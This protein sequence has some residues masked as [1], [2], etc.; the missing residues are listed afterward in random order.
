[1]KKHYSNDD[2][3]NNNF[4]NPTTSN[5]DGSDFASDE[6]YDDEEE[7]VSRG[8]Q[9]GSAIKNSRVGR[10]VGNKVDKAK[11]NIKDLPQNAK[12]TATKAKDK[13]SRN[14]KGTGKAIKLQ[15]KSDFEANH[16]VIAQ[17]GRN[18]ADTH[19][20]MNGLRNANKQAKQTNEKAKAEA[21]KKVSESN[22]NLKKG[23][24][25]YKKE[26]K[27]TI[28]GI[29][30]SD[31]YK[32]QKS[33]NNSRR[34]NNI[35][36]VGKSLANGAGAYGNMAK[37][38]A[39]STEAYRKIQSAYAKMQGFITFV[40]VNIVP[41]LIITAIIIVLWNGTIFGISVYQAMGDTPHYYCKL[42]PPGWEKSN[43]WYQLYCTNGRSNFAL[44]ELNGHYIIQDGGGPC[45]CS[46]M[47]NLLLRYF[48]ANGVNF[49]DYLWDENGQYNPNYLLETDFGNVTL[50]HFLNANTSNT[51]GSNWS[52]GY[53]A[54]GSRDFASAHNKGVY[55]MA[56]WGYLR[57]DQ[58]ANSFGEMFDAED[59]DW[60]WDLSMEDRAPGTSWGMNLNSDGHWCRCLSSTGETVTATL[61]C[62]TPANDGFPLRNPD[63]FANFLNEHPSGVVVYQ[64][65]H[66]ILVTRCEQV[67]P[68]IYEWYCVDAGLG[69]ACGFEGRIGNP[70]APT[71]FNLLDQYTSYMFNHCGETNEWRQIM[72]VDE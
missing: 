19:R 17:T 54:Y 70:E 34:L 57:N 36:N 32:S 26:Y 52:A 66:A 48:T 44:E 30:K 62:L 35:K 24:K 40:T 43:P 20:A 10:T 1:M 58:I 31:E 4:S 41:I 6:Y 37:N 39:K 21:H 63:D 46:A 23:S 49:Y 11:Q 47:A 68:G 25:E 29:K 28:S 22:P 2:F 45:Y 55:E 42:D 9:I 33:Q 8:R 71:G 18:V 3:E 69:M 14:I 51:C 12:D 60:V 13:A 38:W 64:G 65:R 27:K 16:K 67:S 50:R 5:D 15:I 61:R 72:F 53:C 7:G 59:E 56:N